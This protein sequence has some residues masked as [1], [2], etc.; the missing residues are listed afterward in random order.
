MPPTIVSKRVFEYGGKTL[1]AGAPEHRLVCA[2]NKNGLTKILRSRDGDEPEVMDTAKG[3]S[4]ARCTLQAAL[5]ATTFQGDAFTYDLSTNQ[6]K[7]LY[8]SA[9]PLRDLEVVHGGK[10]CVLGGDELELAVVDFESLQKSVAKL[11]EQVSQLSYS[12]ATNLLAVSLIDGTV[13]FFSLNS[14][15][16][17]KTRELK[18][19][20]WQ[21]TYD[22]SHKDKLSQSEDS[23]TLEGNL[24]DDEDSI[25]DL[26]FCENNRISTQVA[27]HP[28]GLM[29]ALPCRDYSVKIFNIS[30][31]EVATVLRSPSVAN[32]K[33]VDLK[34]DPLTGLYIAAIT[35]NNDLII[36]N[37]KTGNEVY[38]HHLREHITNMIWNID[39]ESRNMNLVLGS[40]SGSIITIQG[41]NEHF[42][43]SEAQVM[44]DSESHSKLF[45]DEEAD[46]DGEED[47]ERVNDVIDDEGLFT[48][49]DGV[50]AGKRQYHFEEEDDFIDDDD[51]AGY[52]NA[53]KYKTT[54]S[55]P[56]QFSDSKSAN[57][58]KGVSALQYSFRYKPFSSGS[59]PFANQNKRYLTMN[60]IGY[61]STVKNSEQYSITVSFFDLSRYTEYH[62]EDLF[63]FDLCA[64]NETGTLFGQS[65]TGQIH[66]RP[67]DS[68]GN[69]WTKIIPLNQGEIIT[70]LSSTPRKVYIGTSYGY[71]RTFNQFGLPLSVAKMSPVIALTAF[72]S[73][74][75]VICYSPMSGL[76]YSLFQHR[77]THTIKY[78]QKD[79]TLPIAIPHDISNE[80]TKINPLGIK[81]VFFSIFGDPCIFASDDVLMTLSGWR[82][83][84]GSQWIPILDS[85]MEVWKMSGGRENNEIHV[86]PLSL[87]HDTLNCILVKGKI[88][89]PEFPLPLPSE[90]QLRIPV[91][92]KSQILDAK[93]ERDNEVLRE[94]DENQEMEVDGLEIPPIMAAEEEYLRSNILYNMLEDTLA[95][96]G[97]LYGNEGD[98]LVTLRGNYDKALLR[99]FASACSDQNTSQ[100]LSIAQ[101]LKQ[102]RALDAA[103]KISERA[104]MLVLGK[105]I[106]AIRESRFAE[107]HA[108]NGSNL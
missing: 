24:S 96:D 67:H 5:V 59:T 36:W 64:L 80:L 71:I 72:E 37:H 90:I 1:V 33:I 60:S 54:R 81:N 51:G 38:S 61:V 3:L 79:N 21:R 13:Q 65:K 95:N 78:F 77:S 105:K 47:L 82:S 14:P 29:F 70:S 22:D 8:R 108:D 106:N 52:V 58:L 44:T 26:E 93:R 27:W 2:V 43:H 84:L 57:D 39:K 40:W 41:L 25:K 92:V 89:W 83:P 35:L 91:L 16:P 42:K 48:Q 55:V 31:Y 99:L 20:I 69:T 98:I 74:V 88:Q 56:G 17:Q 6:E 97:E 45:V 46:D 12:F 75:F 50:D 28:K 53:K 18:D 34:F 104:E 15:I 9:L 62:F 86:W 32:S 19:L 68:I 4:N 85:R 94:R 49:E 102:D 23:D 7:L 63:G 103:M 107:Q 73:R 100:A 87:N 11:P 76:T 101:E 10:M 66:F 30:S